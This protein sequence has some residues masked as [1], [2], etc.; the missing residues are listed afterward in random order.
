MLRCFLDVDTFVTLATHI[1]AILSL[2]YIDYALEKVGLFILL[3]SINISLCR[4]QSKKK[5]GLFII[6]CDQF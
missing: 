2:E 3:F 1:L 4:F 6:G 5:V